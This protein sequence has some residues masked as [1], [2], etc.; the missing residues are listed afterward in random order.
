M[1]ANRVA[2]ALDHFAAVAK[3]DPKDTE[4]RILFARALARVQRYDEAI[5]E[6]EAAKADVGENAAIELGLGRAHFAKKRFAE[7]EA[8]LRRALAI[9]PADRAIVH[10]LGLLLERTNQLD[11][12]SKLLADASAIGLGKDR[13]SYLWAVLAY[14]QGRL[15]EARDLMLRSGR[16]GDRI[17]WHRLKAKIA[18][19][20][21]NADDA[22]EAAKAMNLAARDHAIDDYR[23]RC[24]TTQ[25][26]GLSR[27]TPSAGPHDHAGVGRART[28]S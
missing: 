6:Y 27:R 23:F 21:G 22:F 19:E 14:R 24:V 2:E 4:N 18:D 3:A 28:A 10:E 5:A 11:A 12:L 9:D 13:L 17:A 16:R 26:D 25:G 15:E 7:G 1:K 20:L 8:A